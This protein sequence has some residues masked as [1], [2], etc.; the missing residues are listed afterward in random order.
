MAGT[1]VEKKSA[2]EKLSPEDK[3]RA[4]QIGEAVVKQFAGD[5]GDCQGV[6][7]DKTVVEAIKIQL[8]KSGIKGLKAEDFDIADI[9]RRLFIKDAACRS[10]QKGI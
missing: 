3:R 5:I 10:R 6:P 9:G 2:Y 4:Q 1:A 7:A 8:D